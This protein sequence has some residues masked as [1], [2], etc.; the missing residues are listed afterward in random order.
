MPNWN[1][2]IL[3]RGYNNGDLYVTVLFSDGEIK[4][5]TNDAG[6]EKF[7]GDPDAHQFEETFRATVRTGDGNTPGGEGWLQD[8]IN[9]VFGRLKALEQTAGDAEVGRKFSA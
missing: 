1:A 9:E 6:V 3:K 5:V 8:R 2:V 7:L 4:R